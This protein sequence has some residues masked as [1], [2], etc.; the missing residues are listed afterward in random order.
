[1]ILESKFIEGTNNQYSIRNDGVVISHYIHKYNINLKTMSI[2]YRD[3][4]IKPRLK[5]RTNN[6]MVSVPINNVF[7]EV[8]VK[9]L[10]AKAFNMPNP[11][12]NKGS[13][14]LLYYK[15]SNPFNCSY[16]NLYYKAKADCKIYT[17]EQEKKEDLIERKRKQSYIRYKNLSKEQQLH[18]MEVTKLWQNNNMEKVSKIRKINGKRHTETITKC[19]VAAKLHMLT[20][21][22]SEE[23]YTLYK[24]TLLLHRLIKSKKQCQT[25]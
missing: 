17:N 20:K 10:V 1:M 13:S 15:D 21:D 11:Y 8:N 12:I 7:K 9:N 14:I 2:F 23:L 24:N 22:L 19:Y 6:I 3:K 5:Q 18:K 25:Q 4:I 16:D